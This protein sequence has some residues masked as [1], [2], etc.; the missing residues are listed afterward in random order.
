MVVFKNSLDHVSGL[1]HVTDS[2]HAQGDLA[3]LQHLAFKGARAARDDHVAN[4]LGLGA[5]WY[6]DVESVILR[7]QRTADAG[8]RP[9]RLHYTDDRVVVDIDV[10]VLAD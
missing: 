10:D 1:E 7:G 6:I 3:E 9:P 5:D 8:A 2:I 4:P